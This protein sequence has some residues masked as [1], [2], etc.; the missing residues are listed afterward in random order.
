LRPESFLKAKKFKTLNF[1]KKYNFTANIQFINCVAL[2]LT[3][4]TETF[5]IR[6]LELKIYGRYIGL[7]NWFFG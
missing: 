6:W 3:G 5:N 1:Y 7:Y 2:F 4:F